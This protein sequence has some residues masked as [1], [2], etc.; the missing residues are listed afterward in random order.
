[1]IPVLDWIQVT[2]CLLTSNVSA[3]TFP[4]PRF[5]MPTQRRSARVANRPAARRH[6]A[7]GGVREFPRRQ[8]ISKPAPQNGLTREPHHCRDH[9]CNQRG[10]RDCQL[11]KRTLLVSCSWC[12]VKAYVLSTTVQILLLTQLVIL[13]LQKC[14]VLVVRRM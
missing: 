12:G 13:L 9:H 1:M 7:S 14:K 8:V 6:L 4:V 2:T 11:H 3:Y 10:E 5:G